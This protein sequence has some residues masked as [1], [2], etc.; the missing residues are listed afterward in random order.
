M[1]HAHHIDFSHHTPVVSAAEK[2]I[3]PVPAFGGV[4][5]FHNGVDRCEQHAP[6][7][8]SAVI[9]VNGANRRHGRLIMK[10][11]AQYRDDPHDLT[12]QELRQVLDYI[13]FNLGI[14]DTYCTDRGYILSTMVEA[15][16]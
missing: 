14:V 2:F 7:D 16:L 8:G 15:D 5:V 13:H 10:K 12:A 11:V 3:L 4:F 9:I 6:A 1:L